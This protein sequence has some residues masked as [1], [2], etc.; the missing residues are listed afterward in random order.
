MYTAKH[1]DWFN[2]YLEKQVGIQIRDN[3]IQ[4]LNKT[5][6]QILNVYNSTQRK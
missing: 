1:Y 3:L 6:K 5:D 4:I 2:T